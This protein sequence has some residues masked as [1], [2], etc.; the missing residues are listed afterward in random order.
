MVLP[1][2]ALGRSQN[3]KYHLNSITKSI[4]KVFI[5]NIVFVLTNEMIQNI[6]DR[7]FILL[8]GSCPRGGTCGCLEVKMKFRLSMFP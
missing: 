1:P 4:L 2:G 7:I 8:P 3:V 6:S 5:P